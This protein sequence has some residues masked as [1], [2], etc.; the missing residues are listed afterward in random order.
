VDAW[1]SQG[2][3]STSGLI[4]APVFYTKPWALDSIINL[5]NTTRQLV[6]HAEI[7]SAL[8]DV[9]A[10][11]RAEIKVPLQLVQADHD[12][13][14]KRHRSFSSSSDVSFDLF[15]KAGHKA[16]LHPTSKTPAV[17]AIACWIKQRFQQQTTLR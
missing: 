5:D 7:Q 17:E 9:P 13:L 12:G 8:A 3:T 14:P 10:P 15:H 16:F 1:F 11:F 6:P 4:S 2:I